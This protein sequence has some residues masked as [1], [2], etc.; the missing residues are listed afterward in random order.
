MYISEVVNHFGI[1]DDPCSQE[2]Y[3]LLYK[4]LSKI[5]ESTTKEEIL[6]ATIKFQLKMMQISGFGIEFDICLCCHE[7]IKNEEM[8]FSANTGGVIC[9]KCNQTLH[10]KIKMHFKIR[11]FY[12]HLR[13][14]ILTTK[15]NMKKKQQ[16]KFAM[17]V[18]NF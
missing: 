4:S 3:E 8:Y 7:P 5:S 14:L 11:D 6:I 17:S 13:N 18:L 12:M 10:S 9:E 1:E 2:I 16:K 15:A